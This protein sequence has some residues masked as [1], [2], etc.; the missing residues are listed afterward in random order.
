MEPADGAS[1]PDG[2][3]G[4]L[5]PA[6]AGG[7]NFQQLPCGGL[8]EV[9]D[10]GG[11]TPAVAVNDT[12]LHKPLSEAYQ[13][14][15]AV[16]NLEPRCGTGLQE[17][18]EDWVFQDELY[19]VTVTVERTLK[20]KAVAWWC[21]VAKRLMCKRKASRRAFAFAMLGKEGILSGETRWLSRRP[22]N[23][24]PLPSSLRAEACGL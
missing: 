22:G 10:L 3:D 7:G 2:A 16:L 23:L 24:D 4:S 14:V 13:D 8:Q 20:E 12:H 1:C 9:Q 5:Q 21:G 11:M 19:T 6:L 17:A 18:S 15:V